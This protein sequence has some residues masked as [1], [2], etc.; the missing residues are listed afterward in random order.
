MKHIKL[1]ENM[2][3]NSIFRKKV[4]YSVECGDLSDLIRKLY[5]QDPEIEASLELGHDDIFEIEAKS[6]EFNENEFNNWKQRRSFSRSEI[7][8]LMHKLA[9]DGHIEDGLYLIEVW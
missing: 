4:V 3:T 6:S 8:M 2:S 7:Y 5:G 1:F 9:F